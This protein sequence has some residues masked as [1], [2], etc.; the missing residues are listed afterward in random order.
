MHRPIH[1]VFGH[2]SCSIVH[3]SLEVLSG[4]GQQDQQEAAVGENCH[5]PINICLRRKTLNI[6]MYLEFIYFDYNIYF[7]IKS[8]SY[9][10]TTFSSVV[11]E[12][13]VYVN[14][15]HNVLGVLSFLNSFKENFVMVFVL[16]SVWMFII[17]NLKI[18]TFLSGLLKAFNF[19]TQILNSI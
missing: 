9:C 11:L 16:S 19:K 7:L 13:H 4:P 3:G 8:K 6:H 18:S 10:L 2:G 12:C 5:W 15:T 14:R 17:Y 1:S